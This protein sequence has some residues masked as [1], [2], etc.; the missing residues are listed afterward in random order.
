V[1]SAIRM[2]MK[3][4]AHICTHSHTHTRAHTHT[5]THTLPPTPQTSGLNHWAV[6]PDFPLLR[7]LGEE[8]QVRETKLGAWLSP[9]VSLAVEDKV[10]VEGLWPR[11]PEVQCVVTETRGRPSSVCRATWRYVK[12]PGH[13]QVP[14]GNTAERTMP[15]ASSSEI[16][17]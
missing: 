15:K 7:W 3:T 16:P 13:P 11:R 8:G 5:H 12:F 9:E 2:R 1:T 14:L 17:A 10:E 6:S 4:P